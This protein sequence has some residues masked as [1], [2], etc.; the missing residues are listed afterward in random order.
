VWLLVRCVVTLGRSGLLR[1]R[2]LS[3]VRSCGSAQAGGSILS[4]RPERAG[5]SC[6][7][8]CGE[9]RRYL[10]GSFGT[11]GAR[12]IL[13]RNNTGLGSKNGYCTKGVGGRA[14]GVLRRACV[15][16]PSVGRPGG[17][18][19]HGGAAGLAGERGH[20]RSEGGES[21][22]G[23]GKVAKVRLAG[24]VGAGTAGRGGGQ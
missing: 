1:P 6:W 17:G 14:Q 5:S 24:V 7:S 4:F 8:E 11:W 10:R 12:T 2:G 15:P 16:L 18:E 21:R 22:F 3:G 23:E 9:L 20:G 19:L 13:G